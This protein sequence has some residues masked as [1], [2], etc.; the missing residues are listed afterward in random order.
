[1]R[2]LPM[3]NV[4][5][6]TFLLAGASTRAAEW[7]ELKGRFIYDGPPPERKPLTI[8]ADHEFCGKKP[9]LEEHLVVHPVHKGVANVIVWLH[10]GR[11]DKQPPIHESY[12]AT[13]NAE[14]FLD[15]SGCRFEPHVCVL[16]TSQTLILR[17]LNPIGDN[18]KIDTL[19][20]PP[21]N[22]TLPI[23]A[24]VRQKYAAEERLPVRVSCGVHPW[25][26]GW[27]LIKGHPYMAVSK[28]SG[29]FEIPNLPVGEWTFQFWHEQAGY[30]SEVMLGRNSVQWIR[31]R[32]DL[33]IG[34]NGKHLG[35]I[36]L[37]PDLFKK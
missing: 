21:I 32:V 14:I 25:E 29:E 23:G 34:S 17:N 33:E 11:S 16:R 7:G 31:G 4:L 22:V 26:S 1:M 9:I 5:L 2:T 19:S 24:Q 6:A 20:N 36:L 30:L 3:V 13:D 28:E 37:S 35:D 27:L 12:K 10:L 15:A 18:A 8:T